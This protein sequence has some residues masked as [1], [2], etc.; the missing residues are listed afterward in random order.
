MVKYA[1]D[2]GSRMLTTIPTLD[3]VAKESA[4]GAIP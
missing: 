3:W 4:T 2:S 1:V